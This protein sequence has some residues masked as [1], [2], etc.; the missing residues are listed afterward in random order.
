MMPSNRAHELRQWAF[1]DDSRSAA[2]ELLLRTH[3]ADEAYPW[4]VHDRAWDTWAIDFDSLLET[5]T[6]LASEHR[7]W[8]LT[9]SHLA[10]L[11]V[12][13]SL[14]DNAPMQLHAL[15][16]TL[17]YEH[18]ELV[19]IAIAHSAGYTRFTTTTVR[20]TFQPRPPLATWPDESTPLDD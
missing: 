17:D 8:N 15:V 19:M 11:R 7:A 12:A 20:S 5:V 6:A 1:G 4:V 16:P 3:L 10:V 18:A 9:P 13:V 14:A 2:V